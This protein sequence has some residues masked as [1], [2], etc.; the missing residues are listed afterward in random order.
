VPPK[1][2]QRILISL[3]FPTLLMPIIQSITGVALP[4]IRDEFQLPADITS[5]ISITFSLPFMVLASVY[6]RLSDGLGKRRLILAGSLLFTVGSIAAVFSPGLA[7]FLVGMIIMGVGTA[8]MMPLAMAFISEIFDPEAR[9]W[10]LGLWSTTGPATA[11]VG[12]F[13]AGFLVESWGWRVAIAPP[14]LLGVL[15][16]VVIYRWVPPGLSAVRADFIKRFDWLGIGLMGAG[17]TCLLFYLSS[18]PITGMPPLTDW[19]LL[20]A[21]LFLI[22]LFVVWELRRQE[23]FLD[24]NLFRYKT[25]NLATFSAAMRL[26]VLAGIGFL[27]PLYLTDVRALNPAKV[28]LMVMIAP[29]AMALMVF[30]GGQLSDRWGSRWP[31]TIGMATQVLTAVAFFLLPGELPLGV[32]ALILAFYG[33]GSGFSLAALHRASLAPIP[34]AQLGAASGLY[35]MLRFLGGI[36]GSALAGVVL[37]HFFNQALPALAAYQYTFLFFAG[38]GLLGAAAGFLMLEDSPVVPQA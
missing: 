36:T 18:R 37:Q 35:G 30:S 31:T 38:A 27:L 15:S 1:T 6:G 3:V 28:G 13:I 21:S 19:R 8:G 22:V 17:F 32:M 26:S 12:P 11:G 10:A 14:I 20:A 4:V 2:A 25:F 24:L 16:F 7:G 23:P 33:A 34:D 5:W 9:G 29:S